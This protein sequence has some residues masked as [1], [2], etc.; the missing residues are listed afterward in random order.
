MGKSDESLS[1][2]STNSHWKA[3]WSLSHFCWLDGHFGTWSLI[4][5]V[6]VWRNWVI[7]RG[8][9]VK[10]ESEG[11]YLWAQLVLRW[12]RHAIHHH[13]LRHRGHILVWIEASDSSKI[14]QTVNL[15]HVLLV[16]WVRHVIILSIVFVVLS[17][18]VISTIPLA[19][20]V[21]TVL[22]R[23]RWES[24]TFWQVGQWVD[25]TPLLSVTVVEGAAVTVRALSPLEPVLAR[26]GLV[27]GVDGTECCFTEAFWKRLKKI[28]D[29]LSL[30]F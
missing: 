17:G 18:A 2:W 21:V 29:K 26:S 5:L 3:N 7:L 28:E 10:I 30:I 13:W 12:K 20:T 27:V 23:H 9:A 25:E 14:D 11:G 22:L 1:F 16:D 24:H 15:D 4:E 8:W 19:T 6:W